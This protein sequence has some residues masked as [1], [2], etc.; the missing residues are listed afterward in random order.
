ML[1]PA[2]NYSTLR[3]T[4][5][6]AKMLWPYHSRMQSV[7]MPN[8][9]VALFK[10]AKEKIDVSFMINV[11]LNITDKTSLITEASP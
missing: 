1:V 6:Q 9:V 5:L 4:C 11:N 10:L 8:T 2:P 3:T 7:E